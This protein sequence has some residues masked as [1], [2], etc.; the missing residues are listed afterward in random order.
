MTCSVR[1]VL[2]FTPTLSGETAAT[3]IDLTLFSITDLT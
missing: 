3:R 1:P 2:A